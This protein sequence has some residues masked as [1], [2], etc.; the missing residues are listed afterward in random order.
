MAI[1]YQWAV[2]D[3]PPTRV[4]RNFP[5][6]TTEG[7]KAY[8]LGELSDDLTASAPESCV[9]YSWNTSSSPPP[10]TRTLCF[11]ETGHEAET[12][13]QFNQR[14]LDTFDDDW[15]NNPPV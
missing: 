5:F 8:V 1:N 9:T 7:F 6:E 14:V 2:G 4:N 15:D 13:E 11:Q 12:W 3:P 10:F